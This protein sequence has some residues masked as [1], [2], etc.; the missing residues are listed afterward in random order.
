MQS[1]G[2]IE[3]WNDAKGYGFI[4]PDDGG[5]QIF[6]H[7]KAFADRGRRPAP[8]QTVRYTITHDK[9]GRPRATLVTLAGARLPQARTT[10]DRGL[11]PALAAAF[12]GFVALAVILA[13]LPVGILLLYV[14]MSLIT[15]AAYAL[16]KSAARKGASRT[17][18][19]T[20]HAM[21]LAGG[22]PGALLARQTLRHKTRKQP[23]RAVFW[24]TVVLNLVGFA[25]LF[26]AAA[27]PLLAQLA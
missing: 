7:I 3:R 13:L 23:F 14:A 2:R 5:R 18:E 19:N 26:T 15:F 1:K 8:G 17:P 25:W 27:R 20:L 11:R 16:D 21:S 10:I 22:W 6:V 24:I 4:V 9:Q 12:L